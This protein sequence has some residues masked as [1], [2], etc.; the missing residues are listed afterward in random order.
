MSFF[1]EHRGVPMKFFVLPLAVWVSIA[2]AQTPAP[3]SHDAKLK[4]FREAK[5]GLFIHWGLYA[6]PAGEW[7]GQPV[8]GL[9]EWIMNRAKIPVKEYE[10]LA[11]QFNPAKFNAEEW[12]Q[13]AVDAGMK[14]LVI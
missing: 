14:Y 12:V 6:V 3:L 8:A 10:P 13:L 11:A 1:R 5:F 7:K 2:A 4:W 9:G